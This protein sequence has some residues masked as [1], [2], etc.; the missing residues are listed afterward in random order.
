[1]R[2]RSMNQLGL[3]LEA[4]VLGNL[5]RGPSRRIVGPGGSQVQRHVDGQVRR[6]SRHHERRSGL[7]IGNLAER[8]AVLP[9]HTH[10][11]AAAFGKGGVIADPGLN[12]RAPGHGTKG[13]A[14]GD[15]ADLSVGPGR[16]G[17]E[18]FAGDGAA[19]VRS[20][21]RR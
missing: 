1:M 13:V 16:V 21:G 2:A 9:L 6:V 8:A 4:D 18:A 11:V 17:H 5:R 3:G 12:R 7:A 20:W 19:A 15:A 14:S 10:G